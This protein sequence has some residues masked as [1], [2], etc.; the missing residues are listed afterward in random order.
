MFPTV[1]RNAA[2][3]ICSMMARVGAMLAPFVAN[4]KQ[5]GKWCAPVAFGIFPIV[6]ALLCLMLP[7]TKDCEL[8]MTIEEGENFTG[9]GRNTVETTSFRSP[10]DE[11][12]FQCCCNTELHHFGD[13]VNADE[14]TI[15]VMNHRT[16]V[17]WNYVWIALYHATQ[18]PVRDIC[19][20]KQPVDRQGAE[21]IGVLD[22]SGKAKIKFV[23]KD[24][25]KSIPG[26]GWIMQ[27]NFFLYVKRNW[28]EDQVNLAQF[29][30]YYQKLNYDYRL[31]LFPEGTD[32]SCDN[33]RRSEKFAVTNKLQVCPDMIFGL[34]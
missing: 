18:N 20:C 32:L 31:L 34:I 8:L 29:A 12:L 16:R 26:I 15:I 27:L 30:E 24:E 7:E 6:S 11:A 3:G 23:L 17:D 22:I 2:L 4:M 5:H 13:Y 19:T 14:K 25:I 1:V 9:R 21:D 28:Q 33:R 10:D